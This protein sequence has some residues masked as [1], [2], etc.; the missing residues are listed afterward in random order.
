MQKLVVSAPNFEL[1]FVY[2][3][4]LKKNRAPGSANY[5]NIIHFSN[6]DETFTS[7]KHSIVIVRMPSFCSASQ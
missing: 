2:L 4:A 3:Y 6:F 1:D 7:T 5:Q